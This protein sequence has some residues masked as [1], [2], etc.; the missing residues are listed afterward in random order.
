MHALISESN[1][2]LI[3]LAAP[4]ELAAALTAFDPR[5]HETTPH[6]PITVHPAIDLVRTG[7][8]KSC[9][10]AT[11]ARCCALHS[12]TTVISAGIAGALPVDPAPRI[13]ASIAAT[14]S[15]FAD[16]GV[17]APSG[18]VPLSDMGFAPFDTGDSIH[19]D[20]DLLELLASITDTT[21]PIAT[22]SWCSGDDGCAKGV[23][24]RTNAIAEAMEGA[25]C[26][27]AAKRAHPDIRTGELRVISNTTG[28]R[29][30][31]RW[32]LDGALSN[33]TDV[34]GRIIASI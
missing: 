12:Y 18:F 10:A 4:R 31:Q 34:L 27:L 15:V 30:T 26:A 14:R 3:A 21:G 7:V 20:P 16:E 33:L 1:R 32:D 29:D 13:G 2:A 6:E 5:A 8:G 9:A 22:V 17:G 25:S 11:V 24:Q 19:H 23:V 28:N